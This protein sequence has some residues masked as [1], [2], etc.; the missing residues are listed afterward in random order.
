MV[1]E[2]VIHVPAR[3]PP[4]DPLPAKEHVFVRIGSRAIGFD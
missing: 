3:I 1:R 4:C 2:V